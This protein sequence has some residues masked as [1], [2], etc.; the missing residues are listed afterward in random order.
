ML[1]TERP[2]LRP[3]VRY[4][5][6]AHDPG[7]VYLEDQLGL[8]DAPQ[9]L[10]PHEASWV[11]LLDGER[12]LAEIHADAARHTGVQ[13]PLEDLRRW[14]ERLDQGL[15]LD[16][17]RF[18]QI[19]AA[20]I[21]PPRHAGGCYAA[22]PAQL[23]RQLDAYFTQPGGPG[24][25]RQERP[26][27]TLRAALLPHIDFRWG[28]VSYAWGFKDIVERTAASL[29]VIIATSHYSQHRFT[30]TRKHFQT[31][32]GI[33][34]TDWPFIDRLVRHY[35][36]GLFDDEWLA[37]FPEHS[38]E[39]E[40]VFL[41]HLYQGREDLRIVPLVVGTFHDCVLARQNPAERGDIA[42]MAVALRRAAEETRE[43][44][45]WLI[46]GDLAHIGPKFNPGEQL[47]PALLE[48]SLAQDDA[49][50]RHAAA[51]DAAGYYNVIAGEQDQRNICGFPPTLLLFE[52]IRP[53]AGRVL[54]YGRHVDPGGYSSVSWASMAFGNGK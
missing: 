34:P 30:L 2:R 15:L 47:S 35:G 7:F 26:D 8:C 25:P 23:R 19:M 36:D 41:R 48:R 22:D 54:H 38:V 9:R 13:L 43:P 27:G 28:G 24:L 4:I 10:T 40:V 12:T 5:F 17:P 18:R 44:I 45:C 37:H 6:P 1:L 20:P 29:F 14:L 52:T 39:L 21:R 51:G 32:L 11:G 46:S 33:V 50:L 49:L 31:P 42:R 3:H 16:T 53:S